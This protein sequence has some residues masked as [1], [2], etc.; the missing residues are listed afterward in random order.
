MD[1]IQIKPPGFQ[2]IFLPYEDD[3]RDIDAATGGKE[4]IAEA[5]AELV[6]YAK[7]LIQ[8]LPI[9]VRK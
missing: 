2:C 1:S 3:I 8:S 9:Q 5:G 4:G 7:D 6:N